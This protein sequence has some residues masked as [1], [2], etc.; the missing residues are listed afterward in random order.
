M[1][2]S[3]VEIFRETSMTIQSLESKTLPNQY[4]ELAPDGSEIRLLLKTRGAS[5]VHCTLPAGKVSIP[6]YHQTVEE[7]WYFIS[8]EGEVWR[9]NDQQEAV[10]PVKAGISLSILLGTSFQFRNTGKEPLCFIIATMPTWPGPG[11][12]IETKGKWIVK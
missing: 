6:V 12:D 9:K 3:E 10:T 4:D 5:M 11:E 8:G 1:L 7:L 2:A